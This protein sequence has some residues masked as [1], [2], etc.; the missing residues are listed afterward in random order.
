[1]NGLLLGLLAFAAIPLLGILIDGIA[2]VRARNVQQPLLGSGHS[3]DF[4]LL[5]PIYGRTKYLE[6]VDYLRQYG[7]KVVL[8]TTGDEDRGFYRQLQEI[9]DRHGFRV[10]RDK[11]TRFSTEKT[12][13]NA[14]RA[15]SGTIRDRLV[16]NALREVVQTKYVVPIDADTFTA[17]PISLLVNELVRRELDIAS[18]R[19]VLTNRKESLLTKLQYH[20]YR[21]AMQLRFI[22]PWMISGACHVAKT[23]V[24]RD[25][26]DRHSLFFQG[27]DM[28][29]GIIA[30][31]RGYNVGHIP[32]EVSTAVPATPKAWF[33]QRLAWAG[34][35]FRLFVPN[36]RYVLQ[37]PFLWIYGGVVTIAL[38]PLRWFSL[39]NPHLPLLAIFGLYI[40]LVLVLH[41][42][43]RDR[44]MLLM[45]LY[46]LVLSLVLTPL[47]V[48][49]YFVMAIRDGNFGIIRPRR[50]GE[51]IPHSPSQAA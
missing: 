26:M 5:V 44:L 41:W 20:E 29:V 14:Q 8:C 38:F 25:I 27:N 45:P 49:W 30:V 36:F 31:A 10:F 2:A 50:K 17:R 35:E 48:I 18:I 40:L 42:K 46:A 7:E 3:D 19:L 43:G 33:R 4:T 12:V 1:M 22:A 39:G 32:F 37:H 11:P 21:L 9:A 34:G 15:T 28:E 16:R 47:G 23:E 6:N 24:L 51:N 13:T